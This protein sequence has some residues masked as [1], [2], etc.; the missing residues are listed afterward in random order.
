MSS[1][2]IWKLPWFGVSEPLL[3]GE[4]GSPVIQYTTTVPSDPLRTTVRATLLLSVVVENVIDEEHV[5]RESVTKLLY[6]M[7]TMEWCIA[8][9][10]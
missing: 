9:H 5:F 10:H 6:I 2:F 3:M 7:Y 1:G 4:F 8:Y